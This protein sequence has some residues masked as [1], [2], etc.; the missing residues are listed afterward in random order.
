M[1][2]DYHQMRKKRITKCLDQSCNGQFKNTIGTTIVSFK[3]TEC[4][5]TSCLDCNAAH[6]VSQTC[7]QWRDQHAVLW[8]NELQMRRLCEVN[9]VQSVQIAPGNSG[10]NGSWK[11]DVLPWV[12]PVYRGDNRQLVG[13]M[14]EL[15]HHSLS[16]YAG[17]AMGSSSE[18]A[19]VIS[20]TKIHFVGR[21]RYIGRM[22]LYTHIS[23][24]SSV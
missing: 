15:C 16:R 17:S 6:T 7:Q 24:S 10:E 13:G 2:R 3:C 14:Y 23:V 11:C 8:D 9:M 1:I 18:P 22:R 5:Q 12:W 19:N 4:G 21:G 20:D